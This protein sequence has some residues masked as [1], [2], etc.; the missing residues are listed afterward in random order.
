[1]LGEIYALSAAVTWA[2]GSI[3]IKPITTRFSA[4][5]LNIVRCSIATI[6]L[7]IVVLIYLGKSAFS[8]ISAIS[9]LY[10]ILSAII[11]L[12]IGSTL[13]LR[14]ITLTDISRAYP[15]S[16]TSWPF[17]TSLIA[18]IFLG[19]AITWKMIIGTVL[20]VSGVSLISTSRGKSKL[21]IPGQ[22]AKNDRLGMIVAILCGFFWAVSTSFVKLSLAE[23]HPLVANTIRLPITALCLVLYTFYRKESL[24]L[25]QYRGK[26][27]L[28][29][30]SA[31]VVDQVLGGVLFLFAIQI[32][33]AAKGVILSCTSPL[34]AVA[35]SYFFLKEKITIR[36]IIGVISC[37]IGI[38]LVI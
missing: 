32:A 20:V 12:V 4:V 35:L 23:V 18:T 38:W 13:Y 11:G 27:L 33:G 8:N 16:Y 1:M 2:G 5:S 36:L 28:R 10:L 19:E 37:I 30:S 31:G 25:K 22:K 17:F 14:S 24:G 26:S 7:V 9:L 6:I 34:F 3:I 15:I 29:V 21:P